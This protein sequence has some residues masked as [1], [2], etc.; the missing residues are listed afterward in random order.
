M[1]TRLLRL[2]SIG[3]VSAKVAVATVQ[4]AV[5]EGL[6]AE[7]LRDSLS[8]LTAEELSE[9]IDE[10]M[11]KPRY[12]PVIHRDVVNQGIQSDDIFDPHAR[13]GDDH[14]YYN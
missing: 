14:F 10:R 2:V 12:H 4:Q 3:Q 1:I 9:G 8:D 6:V 11:W 5:K 13:W 7:A